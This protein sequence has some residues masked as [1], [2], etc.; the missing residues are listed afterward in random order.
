MTE[1]QVT[2]PFGRRSVPL[3]QIAAQMRIGEAA[4]RAAEPGA[5]APQAVNKWRLFRTLTEIR[6][7]LGVS[8]RT[9]GVLNAL[10][11]FH[12]E[13]ALTL[14]QARV[15]AEDAAGEQAPL[16]SPAEAPACGLVVFPSN[17]QLMLRAHGMAEKTLR[18]H[19]AA[20]VDAGLIIRRDSP[21]GKRYARKADGADDGWSEAYGFDLTPLVADAPRFE[22]MAE[23]MRRV[24]R[25]RAVLRE[26]ISLH[27][28][29]IAKLIASGIEEGLPGDWDALRLAFLGLVTPLRRLRED[30][31]LEETAAA[32]GELRRQVIALCEAAVV[33]KD[34]TGNDGLNDRQISNSKPQTTPDFEPASMKHGPEVAIDP[35]TAAPPFD[36]DEGLETKAATSS[37]PAAPDPWPIGL[38]MEACPDAADYADVPKIRDWPAFLAAA[39][40]IR[41]MLG[42]SPDAWNDARAAMGERAAAVAVALIL[43]RSEYSSEAQSR[44]GPD[45]RVQTVVNGSPAVKSPGGYLRALTE[46]A[47]AGGFSLGP[48]LMATIGQRLKAKRGG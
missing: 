14:P 45:G 19:L 47:A 20:L 39:R 46:K 33:S 37:D 10:L 28:R 35:Q 25:Q 48:A 6:E 8:D 27:R 44:A 5:N 38:V 24:A 36:G 31:A 26:R 13:T 29:D 30:S 17:R 43:Q 18:R 21:N 41:P 3:G 16:P 42:I 32:L 34:M 9:L 1:H 7:R 23:D 22:A 2:T 4:A 12:P 11:T 15:L 40:V